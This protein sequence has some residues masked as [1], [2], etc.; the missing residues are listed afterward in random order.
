MLSRSLCCDG[1]ELFLVE[2]DACLA[3]LGKGLI[4]SLPPLDFWLMLLL[5]LCAAADAVAVAVAVA[6]TAAFL[7]EWV[8]SLLWFEHICICLL[9]SKTRFFM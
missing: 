2:M 5:Q 1:Q 3:L 9:I 8:R 7:V 4:A 6:A